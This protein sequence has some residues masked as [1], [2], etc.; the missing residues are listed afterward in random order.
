MDKERRAELRQEAKDQGEGGSMTCEGGE[1]LELL[2][3]SRNLRT[4]RKLL[5]RA[6]VDLFE[7]YMDE[8]ETTKLYEALGRKP[9]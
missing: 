1:M 7:G 8:D 4:L 6:R 5:D 2:N 9:R 3:D